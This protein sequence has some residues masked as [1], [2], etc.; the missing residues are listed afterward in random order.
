MK[1]QAS[2]FASWLA[3]LTALAVGTGCADDSP[4]GNGNG[5]GGGGTT[6][7][8][9][10]DGHAHADTMAPQASLTS[11]VAAMKGE[12]VSQTIFVSI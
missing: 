3:G 12:S 8:S 9:I 2:V 1:P 10:I 6:T 4:E 7:I 11:L 5:S